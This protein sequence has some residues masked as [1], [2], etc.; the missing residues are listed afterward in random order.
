MNKKRMEI[1]RRFAAC[2]KWVWLRG[3]SVRSGD[4]PCERWLFDGE[5]WVSDEGDTYRLPD[6]CA[7]A[8]LLLAVANG[9]DLDDDLTRIG[10]LAVVRRA[11]GHLACVESPAVSG[12]LRLSADPAPWRVHFRGGIAVGDT[13]EEVLLSVLESAS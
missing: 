8:S 4:H 5:A 12:L 7:P 3:M 6:L 2:Q 1:A 9:P 10:V 11:C 13:E